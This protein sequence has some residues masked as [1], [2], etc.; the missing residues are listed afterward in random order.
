VAENGFPS[1]GKQKWDVGMAVK[2]TYRQLGYAIEEVVDGMV[3]SGEMETLF[4]KYG[5]TYELPGLY[6][7]IQ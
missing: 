7:E 3:R 4:S 2:S 1:M 6:Q 5:L